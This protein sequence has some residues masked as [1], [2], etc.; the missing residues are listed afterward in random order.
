MFPADALLDIHTRNGAIHNFFG[1]YA[2][3]KYFRSLW[4]LTGI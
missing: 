1:I 2:I 3:V 4:D